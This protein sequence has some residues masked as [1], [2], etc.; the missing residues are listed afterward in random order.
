MRY[1]L[2]SL[3]AV[4]A[5]SAFLF[6]IASAFLR[7]DL[8]VELRRDLELPTTA[9]ITIIAHT[10]CGGVVAVS[11]TADNFRLFIAT[12]D[13]FNFPGI[14]KGKWEVLTVYPTEGGSLLLPQP[15]D[16]GFEY[17][18]DHDCYPTK[19]EIETFCREC[20]VSPLW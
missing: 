12:Q 14:E 18:Q 20:Q 16:E 11:Q 5:L 15:G 9:E 17:W 3:L 8:E 7:S 10:R 2:S 6:V 19:A 13:F 1:R 4:I